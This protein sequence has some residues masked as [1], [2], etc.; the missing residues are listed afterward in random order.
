MIEHVLA[1][2]LP[3]AYGLL[4]PEMK[5]AEAT[6]LLLGIGMQESRFLFRRQ[7]EGSA[8]GFWQ[9]EVNGVRGVLNH[10][11]TDDTLRRIVRTLRYEPDDFQLHDALADNDTLA[12]C[13]ARC[14]LWTVPGR[15][16]GP[17]EPD[18]GWAIYREGW[19]PGK[20]RLETW[21]ANYSI[22]WGAVLKGRTFNQEFKA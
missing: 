4:P 3:A 17:N 13:F 7:I 12:A 16:P 10:T 9:F 19:R 15:L 2:V 8:T 22:A 20:P 1:F 5:S 6:A 14:L 11:R 21:H 18:K